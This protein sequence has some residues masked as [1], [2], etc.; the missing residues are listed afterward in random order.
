MDFDAPT[1]SRQPGSIDHLIGML[2]D[3]AVDATRWRDLLA[4]LARH[5]D[6]FAGDFI[7]YDMEDNRFSIHVRHGLDHVST[8]VVA[9]FQELAPEDPRFLAIRRQFASRPAALA[10]HC[11]M[12][13][14]DEELHASRVYKE[15]LLPAG[16][17]YVLAAHIWHG[18]KLTSISAMRGPHGAAFGERERAEMGRLVPHLQRAVAIQRRLA[19]LDFAARLSLDALDKVP[20]AII[21]VDGLLRVHA[22]NAAAR[23]L[24]DRQDGL[25]VRDRALIVEDRRVHADL[26]S[27]VFAAVDGARDGKRALAADFSVRRARADGPLSIRL[28]TL[29]GNHLKFGL[30]PLAEPMAVLFVA[31][32]SEPIRPSPAAVRSFFGLTEAEADLVVAIAS[33]STLK[34]AAAA[35][36]RSVETCRTQLKSAFLKTGTARQADLVR[37]VLSTPSWVDP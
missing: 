25:L 33:G 10:L 7:H 23:R 2:Y 24:L 12:M 26:R 27:A 36:G 9:R 21:V 3:A 18:P 35:L 6:A 16:I 11:R 1:A 22:A 37:L 28:G 17:E 19:E 13:V 29:W 15:A 14:T 31:D 4:S 34:V 20:S 32:P 8:D 5:F 30:A